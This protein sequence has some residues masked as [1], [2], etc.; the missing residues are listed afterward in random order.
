MLLAVFATGALSMVASAL[1]ALT[2]ATLCMPVLN[3]LVSQRTAPQLRGRMM[4]AASAAAAWG[5][6]LGPLLA[7]LL[8][9]VGG[10]PLAWALPAAM[11][12]VYWLWAFSRWPRRP[13]PLMHASD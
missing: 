6:V 12:A 2:G 7:G 3:S 13:V 10:F 1:I 5:R 8:L 11:V 4:G 9:T